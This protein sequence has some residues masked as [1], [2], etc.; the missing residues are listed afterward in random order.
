MDVHDV[1]IIKGDLN[2]DGIIDAGDAV[3]IIRYADEQIYL[4]DVQKEAG[5]ITKDTDTG[6]IDDS[7]DYLD[8]IQILR[9]D[10]GL[11]SMLDER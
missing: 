6:L 3:L 8:A 7:I 9:Y 10:A 4:T 11:D 2:G 5:R 1:P